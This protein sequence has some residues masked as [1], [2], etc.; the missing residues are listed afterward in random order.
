MSGPVHRRSVSVAEEL[1]PG[2][3]DLGCCRSHRLTRPGCSLARSGNRVD[4]Q[5]CVA[6][7][8][9]QCPGTFT[10]DTKAPCPALLHLLSEWIHAASK[11]LG[12]P[13][14][15]TQGQALGSH[16]G[17]SLWA[18]EPQTISASLSHQMPTVNAILAQRKIPLVSV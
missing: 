13:G 4:T 11:G 9:R 1:A 7:P 5:L 14:A 15:P 3:G 8:P 10:K 16:C 12:V 17:E 6:G 18:W 2:P